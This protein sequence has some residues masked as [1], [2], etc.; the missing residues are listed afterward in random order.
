MT[1]DKMIE[2]KIDQYIYF[3]V[4][5]YIKYLEGELRMNIDDEEEKVIENLKD[6]E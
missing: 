5:R 3:E 4:D 2:H 6:D 1:S